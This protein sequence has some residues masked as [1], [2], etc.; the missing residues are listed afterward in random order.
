MK[1]FTILVI[2]MMSSCASIDRV[3]S[4]N[5]TKP[6]VVSQPTIMEPISATVSRDVSYSLDQTND[7]FMS[8][9]TIVVVICILSALPRLIKYLRTKSGRYPNDQDNG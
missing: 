5:F 9:F 1:G 4:S 7:V 6:P 2:M 3:T 8:L